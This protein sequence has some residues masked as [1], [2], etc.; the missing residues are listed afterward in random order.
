M[1]ELALATFALDLVKG[2]DFSSHPI[3]RRVLDFTVWVFWF[4]PLRCA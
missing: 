4:W 3:L 1:V 2:C